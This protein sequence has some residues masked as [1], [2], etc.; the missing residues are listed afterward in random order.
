MDP[1]KQSAASHSSRAPPSV[2]TPLPRQ[3]LPE[4][5][6]GNGSISNG[7]GCVSLPP[8]C[9]PRPLSAGAREFRPSAAV[10]GP[11]LALPSWSTSLTTVANSD[12]VQFGPQPYQRDVPT[13]AH[14]RTLN[15]DARPFHPAAVAG[16]ASRPPVPPSPW[17]ASSVDESSRPDLASIM[18][19]LLIHLVSPLEK[20]RWDLRGGPMEVELAFCQETSADVV[21]LIEEGGDELVLQNVLAGVHGY[22]HGVMANLHGRKV[23]DALLRCCAGRYR[24]LHVIVDAVVNAKAITGGRASLRQV[25]PVGQYFPDGWVASMKTL[26]TAVAEFPILSVLLVRCFVHED[27]INRGRG[28]ELLRQC[29]TSM[30]YEDSKLL[31]QYA[32][33]NIDSKLSTRF[34]SMCVAICFT[35][36]QDLELQSLEE[37]AIRNARKMARGQYSNFFVQR[38]LEDGSAQ[39]KL[40]VVDQLMEDVMELSRDMYGNY[41]VQSCFRKIGFTVSTEMLR[42][43]LLAFLDLALEQLADLV[44]NIPANLVLHRLLETGISHSPTESLTRKLARRIL[45]L[46]EDV[47]QDHNGKLVMEALWKV[48]PWLPINE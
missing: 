29:F 9:S 27:V 19:G 37:Y 1:S 41:V 43:V 5:Y 38:V 3:I 12:M 20:L 22:V 25:A 6:R 16:A 44:K 34:G 48:S 35:Y 7:R 4:P 24:E 30:E 23:F 10:F 11:F 42:R 46:P 21:R 13:S 8:S 39:T 26:I 2:P 32:L 17:T 40:A 28:D 15:A 18:S 36:A 45:K 33:A 14:G 31:I 47:Q